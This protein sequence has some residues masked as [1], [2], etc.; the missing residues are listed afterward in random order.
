MV[1]Q[2]N[3]VEGCEGA[4]IRI[5]GRAVSVVA[6]K[7]RGN[8]K[9]GLDAST[10]RPAGIW[11]QGTDCAVFGN[12]CEEEYVKNAVSFSKSGTTVTV[13]HTAH[14]YSTAMKVRLSGLGDTTYGKNAVDGGVWDITVIDPDTYTYVVPVEPTNASTTGNAGR[15]IQQY[16]IYLEDGA[17]NN[18][19]SENNV[20]QNLI[21]GVRI[22]SPIGDNDVRSNTG[23]VT[24][25]RGTGSIASGSTNA[26]VEHLCER[27]PGAHEIRVSF[28]NNPTNDIGHVW[29]T[30]I[31]A[32]TFQVNCKVAPGGS[33][34]TFS[35][36]VGQRSFG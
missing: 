24:E 9:G 16:G 30:S 6:N 19:I 26:V 22:P 20:R 27:T 15:P 29:F 35:W 5:S 17:A 33:G 10:T 28:T 2:G 18:L 31:G 13:T 8:G 4:G 21:Q 12:L 23:F 32:T 25:F 7:C 34:A 36:A 14:G 1:V 3:T 11:I